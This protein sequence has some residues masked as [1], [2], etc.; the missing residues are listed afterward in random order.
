MRA[1]LT[2]PSVDTGL[3]ETDPFVPENSPTRK[4]IACGGRVTDL[5]AALSSSGMT[6]AFVEDSPIS[7]ASNYVNYTYGTLSA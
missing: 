4:P 1:R 7:R 2:N 6:Q 5:C 3:G